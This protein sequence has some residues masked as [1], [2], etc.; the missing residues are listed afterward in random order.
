MRSLLPLLWE[1]AAAEG[2]KIP[3][4]AVPALPP[5]SPTQE[6]AVVVPSPSAQKDT[7]QKVPLPSLPCPTWAVLGTEVM[8]HG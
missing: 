6:G 1:A 4:W 7:L 5:D 2:W 3:L 8:L